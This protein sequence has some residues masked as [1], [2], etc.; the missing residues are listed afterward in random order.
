MKSCTMTMCTHWA[1]CQARAE[2][3]EEEVALIIKEMGRTLHYFEWK[4][5]WWLFL[6][7]EQAQSNTLPQ[8]ISSVDFMPMLS[9]RPMSMRL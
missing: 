2:R 5:S 7:S 3:Y 9:T 1:K 4:K 6:Q 8:L